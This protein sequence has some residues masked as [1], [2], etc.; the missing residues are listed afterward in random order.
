MP[1]F[2][3]R[4]VIKVKAEIVYVFKHNAK[5][6]WADDSLLSTFCV[7]HNQI[8]PMKDDDELEGV[9]IAKEGYLKKTNTGSM[10]APYVVV[11][12]LLCTLLLTILPKLLEYTEMRLKFVMI[13]V[14]V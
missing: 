4:G 5:L 13:S 3:Y 14:G 7:T 9:D 6:K 1:V 11:Q 2:A 8:R 12:S 10:F